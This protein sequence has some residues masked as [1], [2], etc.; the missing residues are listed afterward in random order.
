MV[1]RTGSPERQARWHSFLRV[2][3]PKKIPPLVLQNTHT[4]KKAPRFHMCWSPSNFLQTLTSCFETNKPPIATKSVSFQGGTPKQPWP[5]LPNT[6]PSWGGCK[7]TGGPPMGW[8]TPTQ[9][10]STTLALDRQTDTHTA[11]RSPKLHRPPLVAT[12]RRLM[13]PEPP[14]TAEESGSSSSPP[15]SW[16]QKS[17][18]SP[19]SV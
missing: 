17:P 14:P 16:E 15:P 10:A 19:N 8:G 4:Q 12:Y 3:P 13:L 6:H 1:S 2:P 9:G 18:I 5:P 11:E 7:I